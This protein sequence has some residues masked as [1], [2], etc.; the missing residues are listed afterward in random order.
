MTIIVPPLKPEPGGKRTMYITLRE[1]LDIGVLREAAVIAGARG[2]DRTIRTVTVM[3]TPDIAEWLHG[4]ELLLTNAYVLQGDQ[5]SLVSMLER[6]NEKGV[7]AVGVKVREF[8]EEFVPT[9]MEV[10]EKLDLPLLKIPVQYPWADIITPLL[11]EIISRQVRVFEHALEVHE[12]LSDAVLGGGGL[13]NIA[14]QLSNLTSSPVAVFGANWERLVVAGGLPPSEEVMALVRAV[15]VQGRDESGVSGGDSRARPFRAMVVDVRGPGEPRA[16]VVRMASGREVYGYLV[17]TEF[18]HRLRDFDLVAIEQAA[19]VAALEILRERT[20][21][22]IERRF[23]DMFLF[24]VL[25]GNVEDQELA[26][27]RARELGWDLVGPHV[28]AVVSLDEPKRWPA[29]QEAA[30]ASRR[31]LVAALG[32]RRG[33][34][35]AERTDGLVICIPM[36][37]TRPKAEA[38]ALHRLGASLKTAADGLGLGST[39]T[40]GVGRLRTGITGLALG[41]REAAQAVALGRRLWGG[42]R[43]VFIEDLGFYGV[44]LRHSLPAREVEAH[45]R[46]T[47]GPLLEYDERNNGTLVATLQAYLDSMGSWVKAARALNVHPNTLGYRLNRIQEL[48]GLDLNSPEQRFNVQMALRLLRLFEQGDAVT[49]KGESR[50]GSGEGDGPGDVGSEEVVARPADA[51]SVGNAGMAIPAP[52]R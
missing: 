19:L 40:V 36:G 15:I 2:L 22:A 18:G 41:Y 48:L 14:E 52:G 3:D 47:L 27:A 44:L 16:A 35:W 42:G 37:E 12:R 34:F 49:R 10:C 17:V 23:R 20:A 33:L 31:A 46:R 4:G 38:T 11:G 39:V 45:C 29:G 50:P 6:V 5:A 13:N 25:S 28:V 26:V 9:M 32:S 8:L 21:K 30:V 51:G 24:D 7:A 43:V 1:A